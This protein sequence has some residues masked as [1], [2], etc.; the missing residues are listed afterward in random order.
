MDSLYDFRP[1]RLRSVLL[2]LRAGHA[3]SERCLATSGNTCIRQ[4]TDRYGHYKIV[5]LRTGHYNCS[6]DSLA[7]LL[8]SA[9]DVHV[10]DAEADVRWRGDR[11]PTVCRQRT[12]S[13]PTVV[14]KPPREPVICA[15]MLVER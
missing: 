15:G 14:T 1:K 6:A 12:D 9:G 2:L 5:V 7:F 11:K 8:A 13:V 4:C 10:S 3:F